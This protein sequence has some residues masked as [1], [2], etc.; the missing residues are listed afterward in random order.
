MNKYHVFKSGPR[1]G[2]PKTLTDSVVRYLVEGLRVTEIKS[3][4]TKYRLFTVTGLPGQFY[5]VGKAGGVRLGTSVSNSS[6]W[7]THIHNSIRDWEARLQ[8]AV[9][10]ANRILEGIK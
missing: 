1:A 6:S 7:T 3:K 8:A 9:D 4:S 10:Q 2:Q 5:F